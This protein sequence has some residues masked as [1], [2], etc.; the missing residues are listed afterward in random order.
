LIKRTF[1]YL[2]D[3]TKWSIEEK[4]GISA[5]ITYPDSPTC[6]ILTG[7]GTGSENGYFVLKATTTVK[8]STGEMVCAGSI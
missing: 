4:S 3:F 5:S 7:N 1:C 6:E 2:V 8:L